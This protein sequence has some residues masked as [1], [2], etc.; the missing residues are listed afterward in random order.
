VAEITDMQE[1]VERRMR[2]ILEAEQQL[3]RE[4]TAARKTA[5]ENE[6][7]KR[8]NASLLAAME[9]MTSQC[10]AVEAK[11]QASL[12]REVESRD[13]TRKAM[14]D[15][16]GLK[17]QLKEMRDAMA[18][19]AGNSRNLLDQAKVSLE[20][21]VAGYRAKT[22]HA[23]RATTGIIPP[24][25]AGSSK[26]VYDAAPLVEELRNVCLAQATFI[27]Q[28]EQ[29]RV[30]KVCA[31]SIYSMYYIYVPRYVPLLPPHFFLPPHN[32]PTSAS[33]K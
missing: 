6:A 10:A 16:A 31:S 21:A 9:A 11:R 26:P 28:C 12:A 24:P 13:E 27:D 30:T 5:A 2:D 20:T 19:D 23:A 8:E 15:N 22:P 4:I 14:A 17:Q 3:E 1:E 33:S 7:L 25:P 18:V 32:D 29:D